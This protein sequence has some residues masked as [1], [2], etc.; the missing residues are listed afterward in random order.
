MKK[1]ET[2]KRYGIEA[3]TKQLEQNHV[4]QKINREKVNTK[5]K[6]Y[7]EEHPEK[8]KATNK[9]WRE[10]N[11]DKWTA[12][13]QEA[14]HKGGKRY[15]KMLEHQRTGIPG[16]RNRIR[17]EHNREFR[18]IKRSLVQEVELHHE[19]IPESAEYRGVALVEAKAHRNGIIDVIVL[20][21]GDITLLEE[22]EVKNNG[23]K[24]DFK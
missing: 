15:N 7:Y 24:N 2:I 11:P 18:E 20:L 10:A 12:L 9:N 14:S 3:Y 6:K 19:W 21:D 4:W 17:G 8:V 5:S 1:S 13:A 23:K 22:E 16:E